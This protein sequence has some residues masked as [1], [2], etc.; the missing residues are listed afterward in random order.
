MKTISNTTTV[1]EQN[2]KQTKFQK[3]DK[4]S[5]L[6]NRRSRCINCGN[7]NFYYTQDKP[8]KQAE[9]RFT[10]GRATDDSGR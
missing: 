4:R 8:Q 7:I 3:A 2:A 5:K 10:G 6:L 1:S 9:N